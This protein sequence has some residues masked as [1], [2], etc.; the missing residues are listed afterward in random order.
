MTSPQL[1][2][3]GREEFRTHRFAYNP[4]EHV[5]FLAPTGNGK[6]T[7]AY[8]LLG[9]VARP[10]LPAV[11]LVMKPRDATVKRWSA[12][13]GHR[14]V[15]HWPPGPSI[16]NPRKPPGFV[17]WPRHTFDPDKDEETLYHEFRSAMLDSYRKGKRIVF[18]DELM[19][20]TEILGLTRETV[21]LYTQG[22]SMGCGLWAA[23]QKPTHVPTWA[24]NQAS[25]LFLANDPDKRNRDRFA[26]IGGVNT[27]LVKETV[28]GLRKYEWLY[29]RRDGP[30]MCIIERD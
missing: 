27:D 18:A 3:F 6:T 19:G 1:A 10:T 25:H 2:R 29:I 9:Q 7:L 21:T 5:T 8:H 24:Y 12:Q 22:R 13:L 23:T 30:V 4:G 17:L 26:E 28:L 20:L 14:T 16:W 11:S 15:R